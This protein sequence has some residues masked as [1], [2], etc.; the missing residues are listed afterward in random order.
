MLFC[1]CKALIVGGGTG[2]CSIGAKLSSDYGQNECI[3]L[4]PAD[5]HYYQPMFTMIG[6][7]MKTL[8]QSR[9]SMETVL[10]KKAKWIKD[11]AAQFNPNANEVVT[12]QGHII[13][14]ELLIIA[15]GLQLNYHKVKSFVRKLIS[16]IFRSLVHFHNGYNAH[17][18]YL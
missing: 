8:S 16:C 6:G 1:R 9:R 2:G 12:K 10:P 5:D 18:M 17:F 14:Y 15:V 13:S 3:I 7:G 11:A 4:E